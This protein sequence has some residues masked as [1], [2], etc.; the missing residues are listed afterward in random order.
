MPMKY[1]LMFMSLLFLISNPSAYQSDKGDW[2]GDTKYADGWSDWSI[3]D[4]FPNASVRKKIYLPVES[5][6][7]QQNNNSK[8]NNPIYSCTVNNPSDSC[9]VRKKDGTRTTYKGS[10]TSTSTKCGP[11][12]GR[13]G[14][15]SAGCSCSLNK[16]DPTGWC[17]KGGEGLCGK[18]EA[19]ECDTPDAIKHGFTQRCYWYKCGQNETDY[20][21]SCNNNEVS[22]DNKISKSRR[23]LAIS[24][25]V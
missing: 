18:I 20:H 10:S 15:P 17:V 12:G 13:Y 23:S 4:D 21:K 24:R 16:S 3:R 6:G 19:K 8:Y 14:S 9:L 1:M 7:G 5:W 25:E 2:T 11:Q 22:G